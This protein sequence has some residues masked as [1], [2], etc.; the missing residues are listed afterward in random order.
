MSD[1]RYNLAGR[2]TRFTA[3]VGVDDEV[4]VNGSVT[5]QVWADG[6]K[7]WDSGVMTGASATRTVG[8]G[9][10]DVT[11]KQQLQL[12]VTDGGDNINADH[13][14]WAVRRSSAATQ[15]RRRSAASR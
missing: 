15:R 8:P 6:T 14:D 11:G 13:G 12:V 2:C 9:G 7:L 4:G 10:V 3:D 1:I 5:F